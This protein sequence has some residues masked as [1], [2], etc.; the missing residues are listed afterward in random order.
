MLR[1]RHGQVVCLAP[2]SSEGSVDGG[3]LGK[4][5][6]ENLDLP[7]KAEVEASDKLAEEVTD[8]VQETEIDAET[9]EAKETD[10]LAEGATAAAP[11]AEAQLAELNGQVASL[12]AKVEL[13]SEMNDKLN[14]DKSAMQLELDNQKAQ[15]DKEA[16]A[17]EQLK[18]AAIRQIRTL[19]ISLGLP[20][21]QDYSEKSASE[22]GAICSDLIAKRDKVLPG[23]KKS[24]DVTTGSDGEPQQVQIPSAKDCG[25]DRY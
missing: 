23:E 5:F 3:G 11:E 6:A 9:A 20:H 21:D 13:L 12:Q 4:V 25:L 15:L 2:A 18:P 7:T 1:K 16:Q 24:S 22:L 8:E 19:S 17:N 14:A 10:T